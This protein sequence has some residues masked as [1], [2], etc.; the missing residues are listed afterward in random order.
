[1]GGVI[2]STQAGRIAAFKGW[3]V[4]TFSS[5]GLLDTVTGT[6]NRL[7]ITLRFEP[8]KDQTTVAA[9]NGVT[10]TGHFFAATKAVPGDPRWSVM[11]TGSANSSALWQG[12]GLGGLGVSLS[13][14]LCIFFVHLA[15]S[16]DRA[17]R[18]VDERTGQLQHQT[19]HD[20]LTGLPN[21]VLIFDRAR[22][23]LNRGT[24]QPLEIGALYIDIDN[25][26][27]VN[28][29]FGH[30][31]GDQLLCWFAARL[32]SVVRANE[33]VGR[34]GGDEFLVLT[35]GDSPDAGP[36]KVAERLQSALS[37]PFELESSGAE[38]LLVRAS[39][40]VAIGQRGS[41]DELIRDAD[42]ALY[43]AKAAGK[44]QSVVFRPEMQ[45][46]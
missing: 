35:E 18:L 38:P 28:D 1:V 16:R 36:E 13:L 14:L 26:K 30:D 15:R 12:L 4:G 27:Q 10:L 7:G 22:Q 43:A 3:M 33:T 39:I 29:T 17:L 32:A 37:E 20:P 41:A 42:V 44:G 9:S 45:P 46:S 2:P 8:S 23:M 25:F 31:V 5:T 11:I 24:R 34:L 19:L 6:T 40:G 21:R